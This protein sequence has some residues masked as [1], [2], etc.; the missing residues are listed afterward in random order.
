[1]EACNWKLMIARALYL[2][3]FCFPLSNRIF[4]TQFIPRE[5]STNSTEL[6]MELLPS[7]FLLLSLIPAAY[8][9]HKLTLRKE[10]NTVTT[11]FGVGEPKPLPGT[12]GW[13][14][15]GKTFEYISKRRRGL[16]YEFLKERWNKYSSSIFKTSLIG[17]TVVI[18]SG[19][20]GTKFLFSN[21]KRLVHVW[22]RST[23]K[24]IFPKMEKPSSEHSRTLRKLLR[25]IL[26]IDVRREY[27]G[28]IDEA[29]K[30][31]LQAYWNC[32]QVS[33]SDTAAI[34]L[35]NL[36]CNII[37]GIKDP[38][39]FEKIQKDM[40]D[41]DNGLRS[42][43]INLSGTALNRAIKAARHIQKELEETIRQRRIDLSGHDSSSVMDIMWHLILATD[44][45]DQSF[46][47]EDIASNLASFLL[48]SYSTM[49]STITSI[50]TVLKGSGS[51]REAMTDFI[52]EGYLIPKGSKIHWTSDATHKNPNYFPNLGNLDP[53][54]FLKDEVTPYAFI[55][56]GGGPR[57]CPG[58]ENA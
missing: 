2:S 40:Q 10:S 56:F 29:T 19:A 30:N 34:Y 45:K 32:K 36:S 1:M 41:I 22:R 27:I 18:F 54:R 35:F 39:K 42:M 43:P 55:P 7:M 49:Q 16:T 20:E 47:D 58:N 50:M 4:I 15:I 31:H 23:I 52:Y 26:K 53:S 17:E 6:M 28:F 14:L 5:K 51:F 44:E 48:G 33:L 11:K 37:S 38:R 57:M 8:L 25:S 13:P 21:D 24:K 12:M 9:L 46:F 3:S